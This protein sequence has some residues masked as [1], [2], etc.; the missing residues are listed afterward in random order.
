MMRAVLEPY[1][2]GWN[3]TL[4][5][6]PDGPVLYGRSLT[7]VRRAVE[8]ALVA[9][10]SAPTFEEEIRLPPGVRAQLARRERAQARQQAAAA[11]E[12]LALVDAAR[13]LTVDARVSLRDAGELMGLSPEAVRKLAG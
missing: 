4:V 7:E 13:A 2:S 1:R 5:D 8:K 3:A 6:V 9:R 10:G 11:Q 12:R